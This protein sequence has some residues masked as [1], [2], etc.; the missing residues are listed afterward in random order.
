MT[1]PHPIATF[2]VSDIDGARGFA[3]VLV[4]LFELSGQ[5]DHFAA[6][7]SLYK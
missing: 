3:N 7:E 5:L 4:K 6:S 2:V 1:E